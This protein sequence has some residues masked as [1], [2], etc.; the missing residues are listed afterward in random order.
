MKQACVATLR[1]AVTLFAA[2]TVGTITSLAH[3]M[4][5]DQTWISGFYDNADYDDAVVAVMG[6]DYAPHSCRWVFLPW[7]QI[8]QFLASPHPV[9]VTRHPRL[10]LADRAPPLR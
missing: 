4:P 6:V 9:S 3:V 1:L 10:T 5:P 7:T 8:T 2:V